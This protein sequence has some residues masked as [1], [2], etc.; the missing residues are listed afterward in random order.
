MLKETDNGKGLIKLYWKDVRSRVAKVD[1]KMAELIDQ[2]DP[3]KKFPLYL[4]YYPYGAT[5]ANPISFY[6]P[7]ERENKG[8][9]LS[10]PEISKKLMIDLGYAADTLPMGI[11]LEKSIEYTVNLKGEGT[12]PYRVYSPGTFFPF[13]LILGNKNKMG[14]SPNGLFTV[15]SGRQS[16]FMLPNIGCVTQHAGLQRDFNIQAAAPKKLSEHWQVFS[17]I[18]NSPIV[19]SDWRSC[20]LF[21]SEPW[22]KKLANDPTWGTLKLYLYELGWNFF[23]YQRSRELYHINFSVIQKRRHLKPNP[24]L[25]DTAQHLLAIAVGARPGYA[26][27]C[28]ENGLPLKLIQNAYV[29]SY[30]LK[31]H[32]PTVMQAEHFNFEKD[33]LPSY[34]NSMFK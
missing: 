21:F 34:T 32:I 8:L 12:M 6:L 10:D 11:V 17:E 24:Y 26:P 13:N 2:L 20:L 7:H 9:E 4:A 18:V 28:D 14:F 31:K 3:D 1:A 30:G 25:T 33:T 15:T 27:A 19:E 23:E 5:I 29:E 16:I 22:V